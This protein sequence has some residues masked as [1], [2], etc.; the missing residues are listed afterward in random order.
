MF[1]LG[2][3]LI[4]I[5]ANRFN[6]NELN[7]YVINVNLFP[8]SLYYEYFYEEKYIKIKMRLFNKIEFGFDVSLI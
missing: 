2:D 1:K 5:L 7:V 8:I 3:N 4:G 6:D